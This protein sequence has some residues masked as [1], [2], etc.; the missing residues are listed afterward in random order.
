MA[1]SKYNPVFAWMLPAATLVVV[2][3]SARADT[4][5]GGGETLSSPFGVSNLIGL[6][7]SLV[8]VVGAIV[9]VGW[10][11]SRM[12]G[13]GVGASKVIKVLAAQALGPKE[14]IFVI[15]I[16]DKQIA[17]GL[18][19]SSLQ[20]LHVFDSPVIKPQDTEPASS[21]AAKMRTA[22]GGVASR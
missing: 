7:A 10:L 17:V 4:P 9:L 22:I 12:R 16:G 2:P 3:L 19:P 18:T 14:R 15:Q 5:L 8:L 21:F 13:V 20:T 6:A 1:S 11:Y